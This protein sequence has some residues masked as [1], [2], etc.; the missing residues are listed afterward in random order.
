MRV[1]Q[2]L[3]LCHTLQTPLYKINDKLKTYIRT[4]YKN[5]LLPL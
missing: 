2:G 1:G 5:V 3:W 4:I